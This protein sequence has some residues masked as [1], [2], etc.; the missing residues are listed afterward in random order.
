MERRGEYRRGERVENREVIKD[1]HE[2]TQEEM[3]CA[4]LNYRAFTLMCVCVSLSLSLSLFATNLWPP[5]PALK[6]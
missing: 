1:G 5:F 4:A 6:D 2:I 3:G